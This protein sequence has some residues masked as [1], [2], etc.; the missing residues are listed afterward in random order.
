MAASYITGYL[1]WAIQHSTPEPV[2]PLQSHRAESGV[3]PRASSSA[4]SVFVFRRSDKLTVMAMLKMLFPL[5]RR[6][7]VSHEEVV[8]CWRSVHMPRVIEH[9]TPNQY[10]VTFFNQGDNTSFDGMAS[11]TY[12]DHQLARHEQG[13]RMTSAVAQDGFGDLVEPANRLETTEHVIVPGPRPA[14]AHK[15]TALVKLLDGGD[16][17]AA[18]DAWLRLHAPNVAAGFEAAGGLRYVVSIADQHRSE[19]P[20][21]GAAE[22]WFRDR[23]AARAHFSAV[24]P[25]PFM[26]LTVAELLHGVE[27][28]GIP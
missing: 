8:E 11:I 21:L 17:E 20:F 12:D 19:P 3:A 5:R 22:L 24:A 4:S 9:L 2:I 23:A 14:D 15:V 1:A 26:D 28:I 13:R 18:R 27:V 25:D 7:G 10:S 16:A 6:T